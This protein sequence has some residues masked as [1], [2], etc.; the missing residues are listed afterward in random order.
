MK[1]KRKDITVGYSNCYEA[2]NKRLDR[3]NEKKHSELLRRKN[4]ISVQCSCFLETPY[5]P[6]D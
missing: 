5:K 2:L 1:S 6:T 4:E 3:E